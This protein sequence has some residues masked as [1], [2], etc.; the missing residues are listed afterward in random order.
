MHSQAD[1]FTAHS[2]WDFASTPTENYPLML[3]YPYRELYRKQVVKQ[4]DLVLAM[5]MRGDV[6]TREE[7]ARNFAYYEALTVRDSS[8]SACTQAVIAAEVGHL[9]LAYDYLGE[10]ALIDLNDLA[11][12][13]GNGVH[14]A[15]LAG[16][17]IALICGFGGMRDH[18][19]VLSFEPRLP[20]AL[21]RLEFGVQWHG[22]TL[23]IDVTPEKVSYTLTAGDDYRH[24][25]LRIDGASVRRPDVDREHAAGHGRPD[26]DPTAGPGSRAP[27]RGCG[28]RPD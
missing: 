9:D 16:T 17:W 21:R 2:V 15:S 27:R 3:H 4:A 23:R 7:K 6:F 26:S 14:M 25:A 28:G 5:H 1:A 18:S 8:L 12:N 13:T 24:H 20:S 11:H 22:R 19:G 10:A